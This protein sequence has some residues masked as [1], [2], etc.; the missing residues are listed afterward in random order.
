MSAKKGTDLGSTLHSP[1][2]AVFV[3]LTGAYTTIFSTFSNVVPDE[4][5]RMWEVI[6]AFPG[7][8]EAGYDDIEILD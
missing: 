8:W 1:W 7:S 2:F 5:V 3:I 6:G 4:V